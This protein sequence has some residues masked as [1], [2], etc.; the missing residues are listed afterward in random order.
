[1]TDASPEDPAALAA[2][3][4]AATRQLDLMLDDRAPV[5]LIRQLVADLDR[6]SADLNRILNAADDTAR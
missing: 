5:Q 2:R 4:V 6:L 1:V 3:Q